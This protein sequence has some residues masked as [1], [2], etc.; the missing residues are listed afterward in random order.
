MKS[1]MSNN[2]YTDIEV[3]TLLYWSDSI[4]EPDIEVPDIDINV[5]SI[6]TFFGNH[7]IKHGYVDIEVTVFDIEKNFYIVVLDIEVNVNIGGGNVPDG[8]GSCSEPSL[9]W[10]KLGMILSKMA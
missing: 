7:Y 5:S 1:S 6:S 2:T 4:S 10:R 9:Q 3:P 8:V